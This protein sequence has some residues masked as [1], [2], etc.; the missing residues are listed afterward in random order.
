MPA[1][2]RLLAILLFPLAL[3]GILIGLVAFLIII[4]CAIIWNYPQQLWR[5]RKFRR[6]LRQQGRLIDMEWLRPRL[7]AGEGTLIEEWSPKGACRIWWTEDDLA[8]QQ[9]LL[10]KKERVLALYIQE[11]NSANEPVRAFNALCLTD[12]IARD[13]G[14][15]SLTTIP[16]RHAQSGRLA[17]DFPRAKSVIAMPPPSWWRENRVV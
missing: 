17:R 7:D 13:V 6:L 9:P 15:A 1:W 12:Y 4:A 3:P 8:S 10:E 14:K 11:P 5:E 16:P 2:R